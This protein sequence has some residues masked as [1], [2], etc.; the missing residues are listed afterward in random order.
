[1]VEVDGVRYTA[2]KALVIAAGTKAA[3]PPIPGLDTVPFWTNREASSHVRCPNPW[4]YSAA[5]PSA[6]N[7]LRSSIALVRRS[8][9]SKRHRASLLSKNLEAGEILAQSPDR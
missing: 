3:I 7:S 5:G 2:T 8:P 6:A 9:S 1:M 4:W